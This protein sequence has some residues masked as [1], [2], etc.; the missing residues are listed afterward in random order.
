MC[1]LTRASPHVFTAALCIVVMGGTRRLP[2]GV[3]GGS[4]WDTALVYLHCAATLSRDV[5]AGGRGR[6]PRDRLCSTSQHA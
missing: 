5:A 2:A 4:W 1:V 6:C 3:S